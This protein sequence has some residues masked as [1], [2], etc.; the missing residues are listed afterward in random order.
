M[1]FADSADDNDKLGGGTEKYKTKIAINS[2]GSCKWMAPAIFQST[3]EINTKYFP[4]DDQ[5]G[6]LNYGHRII[7]NYGSLY[8][9]ELSCQAFERKWGWGW[10]PPSVSLWL[11]QV[12]CNGNE[13][14][15]TSKLYHSRVIT[16]K[17][18]GK[19]CLERTPLQK[20]DNYASEFNNVTM[21]V[22][23]KSLEISILLHGWGHDSLCRSVSQNR[24]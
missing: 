24:S 22:L 20:L 13:K 15:E 1:R 23:T 17:K 4:F 10:L 7:G 21:D 16:C 18:T 5:V 19:I 11:I 12:T 6:H 3:C 8:K 9:C 2:N 14:P